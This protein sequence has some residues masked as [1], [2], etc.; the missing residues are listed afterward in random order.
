MDKTQKTYFGLLMV[1]PLLAQES[2]CHSSFRLDAERAWQQLMGSALSYT[3][4]PTFNCF[5]CIVFNCSSHAPA[6]CGLRPVGCTRGPRFLSCR[7]LTA[8]VPSPRETGGCVC[9]A[10]GGRP[11]LDRPSIVSD[12]P[13]F[14][15][16]PTTTTTTTTIGIHRTPCEV[17]LTCRF[18]YR[19]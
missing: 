19:G 8:Q 7:G 13:H 16:A 3:N 12:C 18:T 2:C 1:R 6:F 5:C 17:G 15:L 9:P 4:M 14:E 10:G 11:G